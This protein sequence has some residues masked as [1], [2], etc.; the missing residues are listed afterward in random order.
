MGLYLGMAGYWV[1]GI[2][3]PQYWYAA[4]SS[5]IIF[6]L[7]LAL[8]RI[9]SLLVDGAPSVLLSIGLVIELLLGFWGLYNLKKYK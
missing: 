3:N 7:S 1:F 2:L 6:I 8:G 9:L 4:T 5:N